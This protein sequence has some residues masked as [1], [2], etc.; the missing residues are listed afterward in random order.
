MTK[1]TFTGPSGDP[2]TVE[3]KDE[4]EARHLAMLERHGHAGMIKIGASQ[5]YKG[6]GLSLVK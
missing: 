1:F 3:A 4:A 2:T 6:V 5:P